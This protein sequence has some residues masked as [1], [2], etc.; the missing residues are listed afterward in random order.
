VFEPELS[1]QGDL[2]TRSGAKL[3]LAQRELEADSGTVLLLTDVTEKRQVEEVLAR[4][5]RLAALGEMVATLAHQVRTPVTSALLYASNAL[6]PELP[7]QHR[8]KL[9]EKT[10]GCLHDLEGLVT[11]ML[12]FARGNRESQA[13]TFQ[14]SELFATI[15]MAVAPLVKSAQAVEY[16]EPEPDLELRGNRAAVAGAIQN[17][18]VNALQAS[19]SAARVVVE[20]EPNVDQRPPDSVRI[21]IS[22]NGPGIDPALSERIFEP[23]YTGRSDG[24]GLGLAVARSIVRSHQ[25]ELLLDTA[26]TSGACFV[27]VLPLA[28]SSN[29]L[30]HAAVADDAG[31]QRETA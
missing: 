29:L 19:G 1:N 12:R 4:H 9:V 5:Q 16:R 11:D 21:R 6:R 25:G 26:C 31:L 27:L 7:G 20:A 18:V 3:S 23:F 13:D 14:I 17:L 28:N 10:I 15:R 24:T 2:I 8:V 22:D 30:A